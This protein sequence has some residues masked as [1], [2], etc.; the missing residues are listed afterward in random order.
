MT[1]VRLTLL[2]RTRA[3]KSPDRSVS[4]WLDCRPVRE[5]WEA[6]WEQVPNVA[7]LDA[8]AELAGVTQLW[9]EDAQRRADAEVAK[10]RLA[11]KPGTRAGVHEAGA[12]AYRS[13]VTARMVEDALR[14]EWAVEA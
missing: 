13:V 1:T 14:A 7:M 11:A 5:L 10:V 12:R 3:A 6:T 4:G 9:R 8:I 2:A